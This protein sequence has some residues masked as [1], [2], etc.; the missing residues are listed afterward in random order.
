MMLKDFIANLMP[1][2]CSELSGLSKPPGIEL[3][4]P[5]I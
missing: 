1:K 4:V 3:D 5:S 2:G